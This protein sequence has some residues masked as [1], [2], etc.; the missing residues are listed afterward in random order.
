MK[1]NAPSLA[2]PQ[3]RNL[4]AI[5]TLTLLALAGLPAGAE[6]LGTAFTYQGRLTDGGAPAEGTYDFWFKLYDAADGGTQI[7]AAA[8]VPGQRVNNGLFT[9]TLDFGAGAFATN[10]ARW[11]EVW[12]RTNNPAAN[13]TFLTPRQ[14]LKPT[15][16]ALYA[17]EA[18][19]AA[20]LAGSLPADQL[21]GTL[22]EA[23]LP[24]GLARLRLPDPTESELSPDF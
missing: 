6:P 1:T 21:T 3:K 5:C 10:S 2:R 11:L 20:T 23:L 12:V 24:P 9:L 19:A 4:L 14:E 7:G 22:P 8:V 17:P 13:Y 18:G 15:P 16:F